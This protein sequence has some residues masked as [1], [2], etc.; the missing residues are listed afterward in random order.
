MG[1]AI[2]DQ[3]SSLVSKLVKTSLGQGP[4]ADLVTVLDARDAADVEALFEKETASAAIVIPDGFGAKLLRSE[5]DTLRLLRNPRHTI[6]PQI[7]EGVVSGLTLVGNELIGQF[8]VPLRTV[9]AFA[10]RP[11]GPSAD[12]IAGVSREFFA[13]GQR[14]RGLSVLQKIDVTVVDESAKE[15]EFSMAALFFP[16]LIMFGL[17]SL[18]L[19]IEHR[20][21]TDRKNHVTDRLVT[22]PIAPWRVAVEQRVFALVFLYAIGVVSLLLGAA[23]WRIP[24]H[25]L[26]TANVIVVALALFIAGWNGSLHATSRSPR[27]ASALASIAIVFLSILGG[28]FF[29]AEFM[30]AAFQSVVRW[31]PTGMANL[32]LTRALTGRELTISLPVLFAVSLAFFALAVVL[33]RRRTA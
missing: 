5:P 10:D 26:A 1:V 29:P 23:I 8:T 17:L 13:A 4:V 18:S 22:A 9:R 20:F 6:G 15:Q 7:A 11:S 16:G 27:A 28:G 12:D 2:V 19:H 32:G 24:L 33:T 31:I 25:G 14:A 21:M 3:D 30:P